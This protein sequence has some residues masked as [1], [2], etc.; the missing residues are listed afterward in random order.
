MLSIAEIIE[1][2]RAK[3]ARRQPSDQEL[4]RIP[5]DRPARVFGRLS[6]P[7]QIQESLQSMGE[8]VDLVRL[9]VRDGFCTELSDEEVARRINAIQQGV[10]NALRYWKDGQIIVD[11]RDLGISGRLGPEKRAALAELMADLS[12]GEAPEVTGTIYLSSEGLSRLTRDQDRIVGPQLLKL[13]KLAN[14]RLRTPFA[15][16]N[17]RIESDWK[18]LREKFEDAAKESQHLQREHFGP[19]I[20]G[21]AAKGEHVGSKVPPGFIIEIKGYKNNGAYIFG[22]WLRYP[23]HADIAI[24]ILEEYVRHQGSRLKAAQAL[25]G[26]VFPHFPPEL[27]YMKTR[28]SLRDCLRNEQ[29]YMITPQLIDGLVGQ[30]ALVGIWKWADIFIPNNHESAVPE[31]LFREAYALHNQR[32]GKP[33]GRAA[34]YDRLDWDGLLWCLNHETPRYIAGHGSAGT[35][36]CN[37]DYQNAIGPS[38]L[39]IDHQ[40]FSQPLTTEFLKC[41]N[42]RPYAREVFGELQTRSTTVEA[43]EAMR[44]HE[45]T[46]L[47]NRLANL[48]ANLGSA[49]PELEESYRREIKQVNA[50][51]RALQQRPPPVPVTIA[52]INRVEQFLENLEDEWQKL[53]P[54][55]RNRLL[56]LLVDHVEIAHGRGRA[57]ATIIWRTGFKQRIDIEWVVGSS[58]KVCRWTSEQDKLMQALW[59]TSTKEVLLAAFPERNWRGIVNRAM[60]LGLRR[61]VRAFPSHLK[62]WAASDDAR[63]VEM[64][65]TEIPA[66]IIAEELGRSIQAVASRAFLLKIN[67]PRGARFLPRNL[68]WKVLN[69]YGLEEASPLFPQS[70]VV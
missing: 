19:K 8:L 22:K 4:R 39:D 53:S 49:D 13:M 27:K 24:R 38:C 43:E 57:Q 10:P 45:E 12:E 41:L 29:G 65:P 51:I 56:K 15:I 66:D 59:P 26:L 46:R 47:K 21:K 54:M 28:S 17:P 34:Y 23:P 2:E 16:Y 30:L 70:R 63:L 33:K 62:P 64:Y 58:S 48:E 52:D 25:R 14:C 1:M 3:I 40:I 32:G 67:R 61:N 42:L 5:L 36:I 60:I 50:A 69:F 11:L 37:R 18:E 44:R 31:D 55:L 6:D 20:R 9:T 68:A 35:W 7:K